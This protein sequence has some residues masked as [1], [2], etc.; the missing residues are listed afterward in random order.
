MSPVWP[1]GARLVMFTPEQ[2]AGVHALL[3]AAY[4]NGG[5]SVLPFAQWWIAVSHDAEFDPA[6][7]FVAQDASGRPI[8]VAHC[9]TSAFVKDLAVHPDWRRRGLG[10]ALLLHAFGVFSVRGAGAVD[11]K[12][13]AGNAAAIALYKSLGMHVVAS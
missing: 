2:A 4:A 13:E 10:R 3:A 8:G 5:G 6:L 11:L 12:V 9:W 7:C 1:E